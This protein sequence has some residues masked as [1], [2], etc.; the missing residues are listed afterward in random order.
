V[1]KFTFLLYLPLHYLPLQHLQDLFEHT[2]CYR[3]LPINGTVFTYS[4]VLL[5]SEKTQTEIGTLTHAAIR[6]CCIPQENM[7]DAPED[8]QYLFLRW[9][10]FVTFCSS[11]NICV[12]TTSL[13]PEYR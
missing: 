13:G 8:M 2:V 12:T 4:L 11:E 5:H 6:D 7:V 10:M 1:V 3:L 9:K